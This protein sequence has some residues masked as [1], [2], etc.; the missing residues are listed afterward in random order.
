[1]VSAVVV[2]GPRGACSRAAAIICR[3]SS[4]PGTGV[5]VGTSE[6]AS[7]TREPFGNCRS[8]F[9]TTVVM[10]SSRSRVAVITLMRASVIF[11][12]SYFKRYTIHSQSLAGTPFYF[13]P[14]LPIKPVPRETR[15]RQGSKRVCSSGR[16]CVG[17]ICWMRALERSIFPADA[18][19][20]ASTAAS[21]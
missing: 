5:A 12:W 11:V 9:V 6:I 20:L 19:M 8:M 15:L 1:M 21:P 7:F 10:S 14:M 17:S 13:A 3:Y 16:S 18:M 4:R 2:H